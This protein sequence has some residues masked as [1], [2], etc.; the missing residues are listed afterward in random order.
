MSAKMIAITGRSGSGKSKVAAYYRSLGYP[1]C[2]ADLVAREIVQ[3]DPDCLAKL[4]ER[5]GTDILHQDGSLNR[6][7]LA[8]KAFATPEGTKALTDITHPAII[9]SILQQR[10]ASTN[11]LF[12]VDG[13]VIV[14]HTLQHFCDKIILVSTSDALAVQRICSRDAI[15]P[16][17]AQRRLDAQTPLSVL[18]EAADYEIENTTTEHNLLQQADT[19]LQMLTDKEIYE[20]KTL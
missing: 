11:A 8:N 7:L 20:E 1:V 2:D 3:T 6:R 13:A 14:G 4:C 18:R 19:V 17:M 15:S 16:E 5:F 12:F 10:A 9:R